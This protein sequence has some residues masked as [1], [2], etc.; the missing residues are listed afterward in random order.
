MSMSTKTK[1]WW[2]KTGKLGFGIY[3]RTTG[4]MA[5]LASTDISAGD[6]IRMLFR[7]R[8]TKLTTT[9]SVSPDI[10]EQFHKGIMYRVMEQLSARKGDYQGAKYYQMEY[11]K[12]IKMAK[13]YA[14][15][16][17][18]GSHYTVAHHDY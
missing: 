9:L 3:D 2:I 13:K 17:R 10:P 14:N 6:L 12:C 18:D 8:P 11:D 1:V 15:K 7:K 16:G 4:D 5:S